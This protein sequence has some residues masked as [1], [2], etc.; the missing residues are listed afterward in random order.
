M[1]TAADLVFAEQFGH[2][3]EV[4]EKRRW[5]LKQT[6]GPGF[7]LGLPAHDGSRLALKV[8]CDGYPGLPPAWRWC[9]PSSEEC[10]RPADTPRGS[11]YFHGSG[12]V[13]APWNRLGYT[14]ADPKGPHGDWELSTWMTNPMTGGC[15]TLAAMV[16]RLAVE[17][18]SARYQGRAG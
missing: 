8:T 13:C 10:N 4:A 5:D 3:R 9:N 12:H 18:Q 1:A 6:D 14:Q 15:T 11:G 17:L 7:V 2:L 16:L